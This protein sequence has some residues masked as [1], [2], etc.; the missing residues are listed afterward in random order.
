MKI[1]KE[2]T[3]NKGE[4]YSIILEIDEDRNLLKFSCDCRYMSFD[5]WS[6]KNQARKT[7]CR[8]ILQSLKEEKIDLPE[9]FKT[10]RNIKL[11]ESFK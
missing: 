1:F 3:N 11:M 10:N 7:I 4:K 9:R 6:K 2:I 5:Y 8:H